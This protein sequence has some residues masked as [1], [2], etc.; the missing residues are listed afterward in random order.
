MRTRYVIISAESLPNGRE[1]DKIVALL[2]TCSPLLR[3]QV[4]LVS[5]S[6]SKDVV[7]RILRAGL[8]IDRRYNRASWRKMNLMLVEIE[9]NLMK[10]EV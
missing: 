1:S 9:N 7:H 5:L 8:F 3:G 4:K 10:K 6:N 2:N